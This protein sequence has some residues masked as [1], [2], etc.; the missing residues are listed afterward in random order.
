MTDIPS[1]EDLKKGLKNKQ[2]ALHPKVDAT[3]KHVNREFEEGETAGKAAILGYQ[4]VS[5]ESFPIDLEALALIN[6]VEAKE[7]RTI[8]FHHEAGVVRL[9][10]IDP[11]V[12]EVSEL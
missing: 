12:K 8:A 10:T 6:E 4:Y 3:L 1:I 5:L 11:T 2:E 7:A 9:G